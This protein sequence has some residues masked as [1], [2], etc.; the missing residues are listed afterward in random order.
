M[1]NNLEQFR[2]ID[3]VF[4]SVLAM[5]SEIMGELLHLRFAGAGF[6]L[7]FSVL[8]AFIAIVR[9]NELGAI[10]Y[11]VA[12]L[13]MIVLGPN[14]ILHNIIMYPVANCFIVFTAKAI[15]KMDKEELLDDGVKL[16][17]YIFLTYL[18]VTFGKSF[19]LLILGQQF[20]TGGVLYFV[21]QLFNIVISFVVVLL[22][23]RRE[24]LLVD[25]KK[26]FERA[27][28]EEKL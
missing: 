13:P 26:Y 25:M 9:W 3:L 23:R 14:I 1:K 21:S 11:I 6:Y 8:I 12:G 18:T 5:I 20:I 16:L 19:G 4:F 2:N 15:K 27:N 7:S 10:V 28:L 24:G 17:G 22:L